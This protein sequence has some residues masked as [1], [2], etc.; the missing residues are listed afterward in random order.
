MELPPDGWFKVNVDASLRADDCLVGLGA[1]IR[2]QHGLFMAGLLCKLV[3]SVSIE[4]AETAAILN[5]I[6]L[7]IESGFT[8][9]LVEYDALNVVSYIKQSFSPL[10]KVDLV[11]SDIISL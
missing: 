8:R 5:G 9:L 11:I 1:A 7:A 6:L 10:S 4:V 2:D 3:G